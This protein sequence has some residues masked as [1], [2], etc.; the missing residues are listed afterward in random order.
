[1]ATLLSVTVTPANS[2]ISPGK[3]EQFTAIGRYSDGTYQDLTSSATWASST[4]SVATI[5]ATGLATSVAFGTT[6]ITATSGGISGS[7]TLRIAAAQHYHISESIIVNVALG[8][9][10][11]RQSFMYDAPQVAAG[12]D[13]HTGHIS[14]VPT[15]AGTGTTVVISPKPRDALQNI[16]EVRA[17]IPAPRF[18]WGQEGRL[19]KDLAFPIKPV[20]ESSTSSDSTAG[21]W[22]RGKVFAG[23][24]QGW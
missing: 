18:A 1:M 22:R 14:Y 15:G 4:T 20:V 7:V 5:A 2:S 13:P 9:L 11:F 10:K 17:D 16:I 21:V 23:K 3:T 12:P 19:V 8:H 24:I 6:T